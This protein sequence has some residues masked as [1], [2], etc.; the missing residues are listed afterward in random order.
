MVAEGRT[1][2]ELAPVLGVSPNGVAALACRARKGLRQ[3]Y[4]QAEAEAGTDREEP[5]VAGGPVGSP[6]HRCPAGV[7]VRQD[8]E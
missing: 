3:A 1:P 2:A 4:L 7:T 5:V 6:D 8:R